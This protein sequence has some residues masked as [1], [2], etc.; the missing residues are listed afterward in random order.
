M[1]EEKAIEIVQYLNSFLYVTDDEKYL[2]DA[3]YICDL[4]DTIS[5]VIK[6]QYEQFGVDIDKLI[7][8]Q[9]KL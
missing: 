3:V 2:N 8:E 5:S 7:D 6:G 1:K 4:L 9:Y